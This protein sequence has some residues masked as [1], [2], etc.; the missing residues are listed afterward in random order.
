MQQEKVELLFASWP[1]GKYSTSVNTIRKKCESI[2]QGTTRKAL[3][4]PKLAD[5]ILKN[6]I[7]L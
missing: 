4:N 6:G 3:Y 7:F 2:N 1:A 5:A